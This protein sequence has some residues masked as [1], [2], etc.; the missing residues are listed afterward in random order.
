MSRILISAGFLVA[1]LAGAYSYAVHYDAPSGGGG[2]GGTPTDFGS[3][4]LCWDSATC[5]DGTVDGTLAV[6][7][8][9]GDNST[10]E[11]CIGP[12]GVAANVCLQALG[13]VSGLVAGDGAPEQMR[14]GTS[15]YRA[16]MAGNDLVSVGN[17][18][19]LMEEGHNSGGYI[20]WNS[21][22]GS[23]GANVA[24]FGIENASNEMYISVTDNPGS[25]I[26][27]TV[28]TGSWRMGD[29]A[30]NTAAQPACDVTTAGVLLY[31]H[32]LTN[33]N[34][35]THMC[36]NDDDGSGN[37]GYRYA[38]GGFGGKSHFYAT[39]DNS[40]AMT[41]TG[42]GTIDKITNGTSDLWNVGLES[43][44]D[45]ASEEFT[46]AGG[47]AYEA[48][49]ERYF[50]VHWT[51]SWE[52]GAGSSTV[53]EVHVMKDDNEGSPTI[54]AQDCSAQ[55]TVAG[56]DIGSASG[57]CAITLDVDGTNNDTIFLGVESSTTNTMTVREGN[58]FIE[59]M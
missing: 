33:Q 22:T 32:A 55:R 6:T 34:E 21:S 26:G 10:G 45:L 48:G 28:H 9:A 29:F 24:I 8:N 44:F 2:G 27:N 1:V 52:K 53:Y 5:L 59:A 56:T 36:V 47:W 50:K 25:V 51:L 31:D 35:T 39:H 43:G 30:T 40:S 42:S 20:G 4:Q 54:A 12:D 18:S 13:Y 41:P 23:A 16:T 58:I 3:T 49:V 15:A 57:V 14:M 7:N 17:D 37:G 38:G 46:A 11:L 19:I